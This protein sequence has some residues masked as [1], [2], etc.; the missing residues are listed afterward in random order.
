MCVSPAVNAEF[1]SVVSREKNWKHSIDRFQER[2][3]DE[4]RILRCVGRD[5]QGFEIPVDKNTIYPSHK[6][7]QAEEREAKK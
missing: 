6:I 1:M 4:Q 3:K 5:I 2:G 7:I